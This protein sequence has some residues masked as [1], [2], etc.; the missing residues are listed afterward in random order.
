MEKNEHFTE[1]E[2]TELVNRILLT[3][4]YLESFN[5]EDRNLYLINILRYGQRMD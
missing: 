1:S 3:L 5:E 2:Q 4:E